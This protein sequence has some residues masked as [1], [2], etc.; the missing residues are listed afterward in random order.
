MK[1]NTSRWSLSEEVISKLKSSGYCETSAFK[2]NYP[3]TGKYVPIAPKPLFRSSLS[4]DSFVAPSVV[5]F[6]ERSNDSVLYTPLQQRG[7]SADNRECVSEDKNLFRKRSMTEKGVKTSLKRRATSRGKHAVAPKKSLFSE[8]DRLPSERTC[9][10]FR[11]QLDS[12]DGYRVQIQGPEAIPLHVDSFLN[13]NFL[14]GFENAVF[15]EFPLKSDDLKRTSLDELSRS[16]TTSYDL[17]DD[18][19][20][21]LSLGNHV[22]ESRLE[23]RGSYLDEKSET[24]CHVTSFI[25]LKSSDSESYSLDDSLVVEGSNLNDECQE[26]PTGK[27]NDEGTAEVFAELKR[28]QF[29]I[30]PEHESEQPGFDFL[31]M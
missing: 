20:E 30:S 2:E 15:D 29:F 9:G 14:L 7:F 22:S 26:E 23:G 16:T 31:Y 12:R 18:C 5:D 27:Q 13:E 24:K 19:T 28:S 3:S 25:A 21:E 6:N 8:Q 1:K 10:P 11:E 17:A 4:Q